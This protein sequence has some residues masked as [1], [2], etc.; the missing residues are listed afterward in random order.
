MAV[1]HQDEN[2]N[3]LSKFDKDRQRIKVKKIEDKAKFDQ[4][5]DREFNDKQYFKYMKV[6]NGDALVS[7]K[8]LAQAKFNGKFEVRISNNMEP[9]K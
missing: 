7:L 4:R 3:D 6:Q 2:K 5:M 1:Q 8:S 9:G